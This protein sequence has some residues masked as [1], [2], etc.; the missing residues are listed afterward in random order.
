[1]AASK[2]VLTVTVSE[3]NLSGLMSWYR[4]VKMLLMMMIKHDTMNRND[5]VSSTISMIVRRSLEIDL[6]TRKYMKNL[7]QDTASTNI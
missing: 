3:P 5:M 7:S 6:T 1:M 2:S 4:V